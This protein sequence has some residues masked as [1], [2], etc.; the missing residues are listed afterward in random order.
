MLGDRSTKGYSGDSSYRH[1]DKLINGKGRNL[2]IISPYI[3][4]YYTKMLHRAARKKKVYVITHGES[5]S[6]KA[7]MTHGFRLKMLIYFAVIGL[8][9]MFF[10]FY[11]FAFGSFAVFAIVLYFGI[12]GIK[13]NPNLRLKFVNDKFIH[14]KMYIGDALAIVG[15]ANLT[16]SG[17]H[18]N[19]EHLEIITDQSRIDELAAHFDELWG[20]H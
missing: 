14:E 5:N 9:L 8:L 1:I 12:K 15:S 19:I 6:K 20:A 3:S 13:G 11:I 4:D 10:K 16:Y 2:R 18:K 7:P 17:M